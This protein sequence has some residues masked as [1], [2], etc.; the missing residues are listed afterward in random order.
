MSGLSG[1]SGGFFSP[2]DFNLE[3]SKGKISGHSAVNKFGRN[4]DVDTGSFQDIWDGGGTYGFLSAAT[5]HWVSSESSN[6]GSGYPGAGT[7]HIQ[8]LDS[9]WNAAT[10]RVVLDGATHQPTSNAFLR[11][12]RMKVMSAGASGKNIGRVLCAATDSGGTTAI[13]SADYNQTL[14]AIYAIA[15]G[16]TGY[17]TNWY[18]DMNRNTTS[19][20]ANLVL[21]ARKD[22]ETFQTKHVLGIVGAGN[23]H[24]SHTFMP[25]LKFTEK[26]DI[27]IDADVSANNT[28]ISA[29]FDIT[30]VE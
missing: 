22:G 4:I 6:D 11:V 14:M 13:I 20:A 12:F 25:P 19:G 5:E 27:K 3:L 23:S 21:R 16:R 2:K 26:T 7:I 15:S 17:L 10:E 18:G 30:L 8:G 24:F 29:G 1:T 9:S 28:D